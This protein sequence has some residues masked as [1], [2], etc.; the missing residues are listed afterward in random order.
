[1]P[2]IPEPARLL[3]PDPMP[4][5][6][7]V[8]PTQSR[9]DADATEVLA[10]LDG[11]GVAIIPLDVAYAIIGQRENAIRRIF[12]AKQRSYEKPSGLLATW[13]MSE[14]IHD[15]P[16]D[17][18]DM[19]RTVIEQ[20][21]LPFSV[22]AP[23]DARHP[24]FARVDPFVMRNST[25]AGTLDMLLN[26][27][28]L[29]TTLARKSWEAMKP[30]FGSSANTSLRGS[31][32]ALQDIEPEVLGAADLM[33]DH[34]RSRYANPDGCSSTIIDFRDFRVIRPGVRIDDLR[35]VFRER[36]DVVLIEEAQ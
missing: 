2:T 18:R 14:A 27:G 13:M 17:R 6:T 31:K 10:C 22:V 9:L 19:I 4:Q 12:A 7:A 35:R 21:D 16:S 20:E 15:L 28:A 29:H 5:S 36:F 8:P 32:Y 1:M 34:G 3:R 11:G 23:F 24:F 26:A 33:V 30:V 25:R